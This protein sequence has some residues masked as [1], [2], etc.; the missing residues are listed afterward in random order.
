M[1]RGPATQRPVAVKLPPAAKK[2]R[3]GERVRAVSAAGL[4]DEADDAENDDDDEDAESEPEDGVSVED[5]ED[6]EE[7]ESEEEDELEEGGK[8]GG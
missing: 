1:S 3:L 2:Q 8:R 6:D 4:D 7:E 5:D